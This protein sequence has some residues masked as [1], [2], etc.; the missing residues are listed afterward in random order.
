MIFQLKKQKP[1]QEQRCKLDPLWSKSSLAEVPEEHEGYSVSE[2]A[3][4]AEAGNLAAN[5]W[6]SKVD[7]AAHRINTGKT[8]DD[9]T[10]QRFGN[11]IKTAIAAG[12]VIEGRFTFDSPVRIDGE[13]TGEII[14]TSV[15]IVG[16]QAT[17]KAQI[18][19]GS[20]IIFGK[21]L[22]NIEAQDL[23]EI[24]SGG[25]LEATV[26]TDRIAI[27]EGAYFKGAVNV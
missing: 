11:T 4:Y 19:V 26:S 16:E 1:A 3:A 14:S 5:D 20:I 21:V 23:V 25:F 10:F 7:V 18:H 15:L 2:S 8:L 22:G 27:E 13:L 6:S 17:L 9:D 24:K 12:T